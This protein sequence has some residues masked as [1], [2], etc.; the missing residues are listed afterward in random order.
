MEAPKKATMVG[1][2][3]ALLTGA[4][5]WIR[6][7]NLNRRAKISRVRRNSSPE[8]LTLACEI[9]KDA[10]EIARLVSEISREKP[11]N[12]GASEKSNLLFCESKASPEPKM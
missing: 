11:R 1:P 7:V 6:N 9:P 10:L 8:I 12:P 2:S 4:H 5:A 3:E